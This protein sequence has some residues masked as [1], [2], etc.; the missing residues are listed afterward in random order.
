MDIEFLTGTPGSVKTGLIIDES[1]QITESTPQICENRSKSKR[2]STNQLK[3]RANQ[4]SICEKEDN[5]Y[6]LV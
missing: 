3:L 6:E 4:L 5:T 1:V 2:I